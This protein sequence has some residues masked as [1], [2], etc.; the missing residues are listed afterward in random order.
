MTLAAELNW[1]SAATLSISL[2]APT[3]LTVNFTFTHLYSLTIVGGVA[4]WV[5]HWSRP[6]NFPYPSP[7]C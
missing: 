1:K 7:D 5:E 6:A 2:F 3:A 4:E